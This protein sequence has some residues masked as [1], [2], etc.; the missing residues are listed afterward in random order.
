MI[1]GNWIVGAV[2]L[3]TVSCS[4]DAG[5]TSNTAEIPRPTAK[6]VG[7]MLAEVDISST[8]RIE[9]LELSPGQVAM[10][11]S[12]QTAQE[13]PIDLE[14]M[15]A[16]TGSYGGVYRKLLNDDHAPLSA[17]MIAADEHLRHLPIPDGST[18]RSTNVPPEA[19]GKSGSPVVAAPSTAAA[20]EPGAPSANAPGDLR[21][22]SGTPNYVANT[23]TATNVYFHCPDTVEFDGGFCPN[24]ATPSSYPL[25]DTNE[26]FV[27]G[28]ANGSV[29]QS[30]NWGAIGSNPSWASSWDLMLVNEWVNGA[31]VTDMQLGLPPGYSWVVTAAG[32]PTYYQG[33]ISGTVVGYGDHYQ[34]SFP[35]LSPTGMWPDFSGTEFGNDINGITHDDLAVGGGD[36]IISKTEEPAFLSVGLS[37]LLYGIYPSPTTTGCFGTIPYSYN[38]QTY[39]P[40][41]CPTPLSDGGFN[42]LGDLVFNT[43]TSMLY[44]ST[45][46]E[47]SKNGGIAMWGAA[48]A[49]Y[50]VV[51]EE[52]NDQLA[53][54]AHNP[55][56]DSYDGA[57]FHD[58][59]YS[60]NSAGTVIHQY[61]LIMNGSNHELFSN[62]KISDIVIGNGSGMN[63]QGGKVSSH[64]KI[65]AY[66]Y[67]S[68]ST[69][70]IVGINPITG[71]IGLSYPISEYV[72]GCDSFE[73]EGLDVTESATNSPGTSGQ[74][75][76]QDLCNFDDTDDEWSLSH[77]SVSDMSRL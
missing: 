45:N 65:W 48:N 9:F 70:T 10:I 53:W 33:L 41:S 40:G 8:H 63:I 11:Q 27:Y 56:Q 30:I 16:S 61:M 62:G 42:H 2:L 55:K 51:V 76:V 43:H 21:T 68:D 44:A 46:Q 58:M 14:H 73:A 7:I 26:G 4:G 25:T 59:F 36:W 74:I 67:N 32:T 38:L 28:F 34:L 37:I 20:R 69:H 66:V 75:H 60:S 72:T 19:P 35:N 71:L 57:N 12:F 5:V 50:G 22:L 17:E 64:G 29:Q 54:V 13:M 49:F 23:G 1:R 77:F 3:C 39:D 24:W 18:P 15:L 6:A 47:G 31:W 52:P